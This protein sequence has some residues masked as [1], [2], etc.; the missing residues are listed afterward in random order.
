M[1]CFDHLNIAALALEAPWLGFHGRHKQAL[2][3]MQDPTGGNHLFKRWILLSQFQVT[4]TLELEALLVTNG[5]DIFLK[6]PMALS[7]IDGA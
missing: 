3:I 5:T 4:T 1:C 7:E 6:Y 2:R